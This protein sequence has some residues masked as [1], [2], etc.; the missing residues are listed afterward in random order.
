MMLLV[1]DVRLDAHIVLGLNA[2]LTY[3]TIE[4]HS[5]VTLHI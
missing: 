2:L 5:A 4:V 1:I 3:R